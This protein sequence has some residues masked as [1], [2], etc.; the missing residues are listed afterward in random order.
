[1]YIQFLL[2][3]VQGTAKGVFLNMSANEETL[4][5]DNLMTVNENI[6][7]STDETDSESENL[8]S[9]TIK[10]GFKGII[11]AIK[12]GLNDIKD[13][14]KSIKIGRK[15]NM[16]RGYPI[17]DGKP[18]NLEAWIMEMQL[19]HF[20]DTKAPMENVSNPDFIVGLVPYFQESSVARIWFR[21][22]AS[23]LLDVGKDLTWG[24]LKVDLRRQFAIAK[25]KESYFSIYYNMIQENDVKTYIAL[26]S[27]VALKATDLNDNL[28]LEGFIRGLKLRI[29]EYV[30]LQD[31]KSLDK[32]QSM[33]IAFENSLQSSPVK[34]R[35][36]PDP[37]SKKRSIH[38]P[39]LKR[40]EKRIKST[41]LRMKATPN[42]PIKTYKANS[43]LED[44]RQLRKDRCYICGDS[45]HRKEGCSAT[46]ESKR[47]HLEKVNELKDI[48][49]EGHA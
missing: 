36:I 35:S 12:V 44:L 26:K 2:Q 22:Y 17:F 8:L 4:N 37:S 49:N 20:S 5:S 18:E 34:S 21:M 24:N 28:K 11:K 27:E 38:D 25:Q 40:S 32:A 45:G 31:P 13:E 10:N 47:I 3:T 30:M 19:V 29:K 15:A 42:R 6:E 14:G 7:S 16:P 9:K 39:K 41:V 48:I 33:A 43:A 23:E 46:A 1:M